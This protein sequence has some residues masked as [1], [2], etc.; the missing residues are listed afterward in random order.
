MKTINKISVLAAAVTMLVGLLLAPTS[1]GQTPRV[2]SITGISDGVGVTAGRWNGQP[3][4]APKGASNKY[5]GMLASDCYDYGTKSSNPYYWDINGSG[6]GSKK[7]SIDLFPYPT[8]FESIV[9]DSWSD[10]KIRVR[11]VLARSVSTAGFKLVVNTA[12]GTKSSEFKDTAV[13]IIKSRGFG[14]CPYHVANR[15]LD[16]G[17][18]IPPRAYSTTGDIMSVGSSGKAYEPKRWDCLVYGDR[19]VAIITSTPK[20]KSNSDGSI[21]YEFTLEEMN[22]KWDEKVTKSTQSFTVGKADTSGNRK[23]I[24]GIGTAASSKWVATGFYR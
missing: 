20:K 4:Y 9:I 3:S 11:V 8:P 5:V 17:L 2:K 22:A 19:H 15:R 7:G 21:T 13:S 24:K 18:P 16:K 23:V 12:N 6:F 1:F 14:Q 10:T